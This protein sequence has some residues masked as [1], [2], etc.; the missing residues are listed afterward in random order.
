MQGLLEV[1]NRHDATVGM[2]IKASK[3][4]VKSA[5]ISGE[6]IQA[7]LLDSESVKDV[8]KRSSQTARAP[9]RSEA[10]LILLVLHSLVWNPVLVKLMI[11]L[12]LVFWRINPI[13]LLPDLIGCV[14]FCGSEPNHL[15]AFFFSRGCGYRA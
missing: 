2:F 15:F 1:V 4:K 14:V 8:D 9:R 12:G 5:L 6:Q 10:G 3:T 13:E 11:F 7:V